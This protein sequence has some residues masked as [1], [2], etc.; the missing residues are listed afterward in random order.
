MTPGFPQVP[1]KPTPCCLPLPLSVYSLSVLALYHDGPDMKFKFFTNFHKQHLLKRHMNILKTWE[2]WRAHIVY[3]KA[4]NLEIPNMHNWSP[5]SFL[6]PFSE[7]PSSS[8][9]FLGPFSPVVPR[10]FLSCWVLPSPLQVALGT[11]KILS[12]V[13]SRSEFPNSYSSSS[14]S[15]IERWCFLTREHSHLKALRI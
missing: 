14:I 11:I 15:G 8:R 4:N 5:K 7:P 6:S 12:N 9:C 10:L 2:S 3:R 13:Q 1:R